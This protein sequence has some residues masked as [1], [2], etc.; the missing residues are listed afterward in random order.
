MPNELPIAACS[1]DQGR[2]REF[3]PRG[4]QLNCHRD[5]FGYYASGVDFG[6]RVTVDTVATRCL[7]TVEGRVSS[8]Q[9]TLSVVSIERRRPRHR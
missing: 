8:R 4:V 7:A 3:R 6:A 1:I 9:Q 5:R 2:G